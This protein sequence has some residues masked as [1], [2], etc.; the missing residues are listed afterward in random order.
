MRC[1]TVFLADGEAPLFENVA[2]G[3]LI[4]G[5]EGENILKMMSVPRVDVMPFSVGSGSIGTPEQWN[6][7]LGEYALDAL[8]GWTEHMRQALTERVRALA[9]CYQEEFNRAAEV[10]LLTVRN[11]PRVTSMTTG[12]KEGFDASFKCGMA[13]WAAEPKELADMKHTEDFAFQHEWK[14]ADPEFLDGRD[15]FLE[16]ATLQ[17]RVGLLG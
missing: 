16:W 2:P 12:E 7:S 1:Y 3:A 15:Q 4:I 8:D 14:R 11:Y 6:E 10:C 13:V 17:L 5:H 9:E